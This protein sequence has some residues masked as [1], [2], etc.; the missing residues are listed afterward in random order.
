MVSMRLV[1][2]TGIIILLFCLIFVFK[3]F[4]PEKLPAT[5]PSELERIII[6]FRPITPRFYRDNLIS[7]YGALSSEPLRLKDT[8]VINVPRG[9]LE[10]IVSRLGKNITVEYVE[11]DYQAEALDVPNDPQYV[12]QWGLT[13]ID[14]PGGWDESHGES[15]DIAILDT[16]INSSHPDLSSKIFISVNCTISSSCPTQTTTD[17]DGHGTHVAGIASAVTNNSLGIAG[18]DWDGRLMSVK[19]LD[20]SGGGFYSW[21]SNGIIWAA[22]NGAEVINLSLG[23]SSASSTLESAVNYAWN[24]GVVVVA[25]AGNDGRNRRLYPAY[26]TNAIAVGATDAN[27]QKASFSNYGTWV[28]VAAPGVSILSTYHNSYSSLSG[29]SMATPFVSGL[30]GLLISQNPQWSDSQ[31]RNQIESTADF[32]TG[33]GAYFKWGRINI[34]RALGCSSLPSPTPTPTSTPT[35]NPTPT[36]IP[37][38]TPSLTPTLTPT[39]TLTPMPTPLITPTPTPTQ[40]LPWWCKYIPNHHTCQP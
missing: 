26:Y 38:L 39:L 8:I 19:V 24:K 6:K 12:A 30:A 17:P 28:D 32:V 9:A 14:A 11:A 10:S 15:V 35:P 20:D 33:T 40:Q 22:D 16:G 3:A 18:V 27:D 34:C 1:F 37:T 21:I 4:W 31:V 7:A 25:A 5:S 23:G 13:K 29:T 36:L 2:K